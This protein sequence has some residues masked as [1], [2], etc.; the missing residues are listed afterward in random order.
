MVKLMNYSDKLPPLKKR[1]WSS[2]EKRKILILAEKVRKILEK[3][4][5]SDAGCEENISSSRN[6]FSY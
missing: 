6:A 3:E 5:K 1:S 4:R 2:E